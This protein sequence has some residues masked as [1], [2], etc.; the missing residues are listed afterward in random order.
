MSAARLTGKP[1]GV[2]STCEKQGLIRS[3]GHEGASRE[4]VF[5]RPPPS[6]G[7]AAASVLRACVLEGGVQRAPRG[8]SATTLTTVLKVTATL[9]PILPMRRLRLRETGR[10]GKGQLVSD[11][12]PQHRCPGA[13]V[14]QTASGQSQ[15]DRHLLLPPGQSCPA[16]RGRGPHSSDGQAAQGSLHAHCPGILPPVGTSATFCPSSEPWRWPRQGY[17]LG[18]RRLPARHRL[19][20]EAD[21]SRAEKLPTPWAPCTSPAN[22]SRRPTEQT[23]T[24]EAN[25]KTPLE[26]P[27]WTAAVRRGL[28]PPGVCSDR[29]NPEFRQARAGTSA[30]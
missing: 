4:D 25:T 27:G 24:S 22:L 10:R 28:L 21:V 30:G 8:P 23:T 26:D 13:P 7:N 18:G 6:T 15:R 2:R 11:K 20:R 19:R 16:G 9:G 3:W 5:K 17:T 29:T 14:V 1:P 12:K